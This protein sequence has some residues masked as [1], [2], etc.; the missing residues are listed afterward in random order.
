MSEKE[1]ANALP[2]EDYE[3]DLL[4]LEDDEGTEHTF[5]VLDA[6]D[7]DGVRYLAMVPYNENAAQSLES[8]AEMIIMR[9]GEGEGDEEFLDIVDDEDELAA[10]GQVFLTRLQ[11]LYDID[12]DELAGQSPGKD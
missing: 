7:V 3:P 9:A 5:E 8:D 12:L 11:E 1:A 2:D 6:T 4:T 10:V